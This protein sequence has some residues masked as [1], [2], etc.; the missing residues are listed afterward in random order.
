MEKSEKCLCD[1]LKGKSKQELMEW[2]F[3]QFYRLACL[4]DTKSPSGF[5]QGKFD[6][7]YNDYIKK[8]N[9]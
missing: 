7:T 4:P 5:H 3:I 6:Q 8:A 2:Y 9:S 1:E